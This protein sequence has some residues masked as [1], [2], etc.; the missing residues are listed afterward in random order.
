MHKVLKMVVILWAWGC[1][2]WSAWS[3]QWY[4]FPLS[5]AP[6]L[7]LNAFGHHLEKKKE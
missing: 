7:L 4:W 1:W 5:F 2:A 3:G 6:Y